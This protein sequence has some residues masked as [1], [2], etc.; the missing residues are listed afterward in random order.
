MLFPSFLCY[1]QDTIK[2]LILFIMASEHIFYLCL[3]ENL[4]RKIAKQY[5]CH[6]I[7]LMGKLE[8][9]ELL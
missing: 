7:L 8:M 4:K 2:M 6:I 3:L 1:T 9:R 5:H